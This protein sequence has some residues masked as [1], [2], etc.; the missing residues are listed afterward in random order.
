MVPARGLLFS[1]CTMGC[2]S[3]GLGGNPHTRSHAGCH[4]QLTLFV[5][6]LAETS[7]GEDVNTS[8]W[9]GVLLYCVVW[10]VG[11]DDLEKSKLKN[12]VPILDGETCDYLPKFTGKTLPSAFTLRYITNV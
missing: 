4:V 8:C 3:C 10:G 6:R 9:S 11:C 7:H 1:N 12:L 5:S 2:L